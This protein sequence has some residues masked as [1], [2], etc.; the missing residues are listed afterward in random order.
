MD[1]ALRTAASPKRLACFA[2]IL[3]AL[4]VPFAAN[5]AEPMLQLKLLHIRRNHSFRS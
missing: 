1:I 5:I 4:H 3:F 2:A